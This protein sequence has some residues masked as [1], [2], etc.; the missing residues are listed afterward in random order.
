MILYGA[1]LS[2][3]VARVLCAVRRKGLDVRQAEPP[4]GNMKSP[5]YLALNP[6]GKIPTLVGEDGPV[7]ESEVICEYLEEK[8]PQ[9]P[10]LPADPAGRA[11]SRTVSRA[12]DLYVLPGL[13]GLLGQL[14]PTTRDSAVVEEK[15]AELRRGLDGLEKLLKGPYALGPELTLADC[16]L[17]PALFYLDRFMPAFGKFDALADHPTLRTVWTTLRA[18]PMVASLLADMAASLDDF[19]RR[20][21][22][23]AS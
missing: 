3:Y 15:L 22:A 10:L 17:V 11:R 2:P 16:A 12:V 23:N 14:N 13:L 4:G 20:R 19:L 7:F 9:P 6:Y 1:A 18:E 21:A 5:E 8:S